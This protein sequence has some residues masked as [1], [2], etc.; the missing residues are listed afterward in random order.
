MK[1][2]SPLVR[3]SVLL[4][5]LALFLSLL[6]A[7]SLG[8]SDF[9]GRVDAHAP[10]APAE[11][12]EPPAPVTSLVAEA[13]LSPGTVELSWIAPGDDGATGT[14][15][16]YVVRYNTVPITGSNWVDSTDVDGEPTPAPAGSVESMMVSGLPPGPAYYF[17]LKTRD[18]VPNLSSV[19]NSP[20]ALPRPSPNAAF[21]PLNLST[22]GSYPPVI[23]ET[24]EVLPPETTQHLEAI[25]DSGA[26][27]TFTQSTPDLAE[28]APGEIMVGDVT[29]NAP[30]G[31]LR[32]VTSVSTNGGQVIVETEEATLEEAIESGSAAV[33]QA[34]TPAQIQGGMLAPGVTLAA[35][36]MAPNGPIFQYTL[37]HVVLY[38]RDGNQIWADGRIQ[39]EASFDFS[40][41]VSWF[42]LKR[43]SFKTTVHEES[44]LEI[45]AAM[46]RFLDE[47]RVIARHV[48]GPI[49]VPIG[50]VPV[51]LVPV[52]SVHVGADGSIH[53]DVRTGATQEAMLTAQLRYANGSWNASKTFSN[54]FQFNP[55]ALSANL[56]V[57]G[58]AGAELSLLLYGVAGPYVRTDIYLELEAD[59]NQTP[60]WQLYGGLKVP[61]GVKI[62]ALGKTLASYET[63]AINYRVLLARAQVNSVPNLPS[64]PN[65]GDG[66]TGQSRDVDLGWLGGDPDGDTVT[67]DV[68]LEADDATPDV[69][70]SG[71]Q[72]GTAYDPG[73]LAADKDYYWRIVARDQHGAT[74]A[75]PVWHLTT[76][77]ED[78]PP[79]VMVYVPAGTFQMGCDQGNPS[80][81]CSGDELPLHAVYLGAYA[82]DTYEVTN[83]QYAGCV[84][85]GA[86][87]PPAHAYSGTRGSYYGNPIYADYPVLYV[88]WED[89]TDY[90]AWAGKRLPTEAEWEKAARGSTGTRMYP[91]GNIAPDCSRLNYNRCL[92]DTMPVGDYAT[93][94]SPY[95]VWNMGGNV[96]EWVNDWYDADYYDVSPP[97]NPKGPVSGSY[98]VMRGGSWYDPW[99]YTRVARR[100]S[101]VP[102]LGGYNVGFRCAVSSGDLPTREVDEEGLPGE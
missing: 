70:V 94:Q 29:A 22:T 26:V 88:S 33:S 34:L 79:G 44:E 27:Y 42:T 32:K 62:E 9:G 67:Y 87:T 78:T 90:C 47:E 38:E 21:L 7:P 14:A 71:G 20:W 82:I 24:T 17:A 31:F 1:S 45:T 102:T 37:D 11:D 84:A 93:G 74:N 10:S 4:S 48:F 5:L 73:T 16:A 80:E 64:H 76:V 98:R 91:W 101:D 41:A 28:L 15:T 100:H 58:Y 97:S 8:S 25:S 75:G 30:S 50:P 60:W 19:S 49:T 36:P 59:I 35:A 69:L 83:A 3:W 81:S 92:G 86:C 55:P 66:A 13:G 77:P 68:Y 53:V 18:E 51:V 12:T 43:V 72:A 85:A 54:E 61:I 23:P 40:V 6:P 96:W 99:F 63:N 2:R 89:A 46:D 57:M 95:G 52:L 39:I 65:P 56:D